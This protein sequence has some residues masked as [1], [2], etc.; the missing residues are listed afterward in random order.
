SHHSANGFFA[1]DF[2]YFLAHGA[3]NA[4]LRALQYGVDGPNG[5]LLFSPGGQ[6][7]STGNAGHNFWVDVLFSTA[8]SARTP[9]PPVPAPSPQ[10]ITVVAGSSQS[11]T[12]GAAFSVPLQVKVLDGSSK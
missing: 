9:P 6:F 2:D 8:G 10:S 4:P 12:V 7:P 5:L 3:D 1:V 11:A